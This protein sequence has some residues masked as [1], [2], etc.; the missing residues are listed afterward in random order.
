MAQYMQKH[1]PCIYCVKNSPEFTGATNEVT[2]WEFD[3]PARNEF[4]P[5]EK[6]VPLI[7]RAISNHP[8]ELVYEPFSGSGTTLIACEN[9]S[10]KCRAVEVSPAYVAVALQRYQDAFGITAELMHPGKAGHDAE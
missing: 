5:T 7:Q 8:Y 6:P 10:R 3:Q 4:H 9:L 1:E 2:V